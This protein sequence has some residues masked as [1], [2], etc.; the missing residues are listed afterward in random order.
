ILIDE[1]GR[2]ARIFAAN[3]AATAKHRK[4]HGL[5]RP[6]RFRAAAILPS[7]PSLSFARMAHDEGNHNIPTHFKGARKIPF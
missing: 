5:F 3:S 2:R 1:E 6:A 4:F 7:A